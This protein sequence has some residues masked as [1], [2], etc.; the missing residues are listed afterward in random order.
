MKQVKQLSE[1]PENFQA[2]FKCLIKKGLSN[3]I[4]IKALKDEHIQMMIKLEKGTTLRNFKRL[5]GIAN[6]VCELEISPGEAAL[7]MHSGLATVSALANSTPT[8]VLTQIGKLERHLNTCRQ[9]PVN[10]SSATTWIHRAKARQI[11]K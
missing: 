3:W 2:E 11:E 5:R 9:T 6:L 10:L 1:L 4:D 8:D 7:L